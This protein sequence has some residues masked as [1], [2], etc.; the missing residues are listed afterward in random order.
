MRTRSSSNLP[1]VSPNPSTSNP[2]RRNRRHS[3]QPFILE[4]SPVDT[5]ADQRT[6]AELLRAPTEGYAEA[7]VVPPILAEQF[8]LK[9]SLINMMNSDQFFRLEKDNTHDHIQIAKLTHAV[10]QQTSVVTTAMIAI[11]KQFQATPPPAFV[12]VVEEICVTCVGAHPYYQCLAGGG[13]TFPELR[14]N[15]QGY[16][17]AAV[18]NYNLGNSVYHPPEKDER[19]EE[20]LTDQDLS[21]YTIKVP[22]PHVQKYK[23]LSQRDFVVH[24]RDPLHPNIPYPSRMVKQK[25]Q[26]KDEVQIYKFWQMFKQLHINITLVDAL[27]LMPK[28]QKM[29][30]ALLSNKE[31]LQELANTPLNENCLA[32]QP[33]QSFVTQQ[34]PQ[35]SNEDIRLEMVKLIKNNR[36]LLNNNIFPHEEAK[37]LPRLLNDSQTINEILKQREQAANLAVQKEQEEQAIQ[38]FTPYWN[39]S[40]IDD[41]EVLQSREKFMKAI[42]TFLQKF[43]RYSFGV[44]PNVLLIAW[45]RF[46]KIK[47]AFTD[48]QYQP[49][50]IQELMCKLLEDVRNINEELSEYINSPNIEYVEASL[51][52][53]KFVSLEEENDVYQEEKEFDL[54]YI[55]QIQ[56][57]I[58]HEKLLSI[59]R[60]IADIEFLNDNSTPDRVLKSSSSFPIFEKSN[61]SLSYSDNSLLEFETF[62]N[63]T[64]ETRSGSTTAH[65]NNSPFEYDSFCCEIEHDQG[66]LTSVVKNDISDNSTNDPLLEVVDL[67][68]VLDNSIPPGIKN[69]D[70]D[71][72]GDIYF[73]EE[74]VVNDSIPLPKNESSNFDHHDDPSFPRPPPEPPDVEFFFD[75]EP[76]SGELISV[77]MNNIDE[78]NKDE[79]FDPGGE[80]P[81]GEIKIHIEVLVVLLGNRLPIRT[82]RYRWLGTDI[83][84]ITKKGSKP[85]KN[86]HEILSSRSYLKKLGD[87]GKF[88]IMC[89]FNERK[90]KALSDLGAR[91]NLMPLYIWKKLGLPELIS[92]R[93][94][95]ELANRAIFTPAGIA[96]D[97]FVSVGKFTFPADFVIVDYES[98]PRVPLILGRPFLQIAR[99]LIDVPGEE[100]ILC[101]DPIKDIDSILKDSIDQNN[102]ADL[103]DNLIKHALDYSSPP[104]F[105]DYDDDLFEVESNTE[106]VYDD[107]F[108]SKG[109]KIKESK[110]LIDE[111]NLPCDFLL[112][113]EYD[114]FISKDFSRVDALPSTNNEDKYSWNSK[115]HAKDFVLQFSFPQLHLGI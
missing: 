83:A 62:S 23:R 96:R 94:T 29:L 43:S 70:Y 92:T 46:S 87:P 2:K 52:D 89:G 53:S 28:Y 103:N 82:V 59:N 36:I 51:L 88:L 81:S 60:L 66:R 84:K 58:L 100:M 55:L 101:E 20:T 33:L 32:Y 73:L 68:L 54:E 50:E 27:I 12:K 114:S 109:E 78:L 24:Q 106:N 90:C 5:M 44:M 67:F 19:V 45:E 64:E 77:V 113:S 63:H 110:L 99:A 47:H 108:D 79:S 48:K 35:R 112:P 61:N 76:N 22:P 14:D 65:A 16:V 4:E 30:K 38:S 9:H 107:P 69:I 85:D 40:M 10:N 75:F 7:I 74:L 8:E 17:A 98:D 86:E 39:F 25:Q 1:V 41:E 3:K 13:N 49:E 97:V 42:Q 72:E 26:E 93:M 104:L 6:M 34:I 11:L 91:I 102:L 31:K 105:D 111:L 21:E 15:I 57:V 18:V 71:S 95:L 80:I 115:T 56:D 37:L